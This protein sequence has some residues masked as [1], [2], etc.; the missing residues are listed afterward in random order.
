MEQNTTFQAS[1][2]AAS[3]HS[4]VVVTTGTASGKSMAFNLPVLNALA[5]EPKLR[6][7]YLYPTKALA[8]DQA[9][10]LASFHLPRLRGRPY[11]GKHPLC[12][13]RGTA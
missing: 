5:A 4:D 11:G 6:A 7:L 13:Q 12:P 2:F 3:E 1:A 10:T 9:R 8:Q